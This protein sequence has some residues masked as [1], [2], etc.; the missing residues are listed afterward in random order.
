MAGL[1]GVGAAAFDSV[2]AV[3]ARAAAPTR[4]GTLRYG[5]NTPITSLDPH[6][7]T[8]AAADNCLGI[9]YSRLVQLSPDW[10]AFQPD[11]ADRWTV[12]S[13]GKAYTF[14]LRPNVKFHDG[15]TLTAD[16]VVFSFQRIMDPK[17]GAYVQ[18][19]L[20]DVFDQVVAPD[21]SNVRFVLTRPYSAVLAALALPTASIVSKR[22]V[23][24]GGNLE[25]A[26]MGTGAMKFVSLE[27]GVKITLA[28]HTQYYDPALPYLDGMQLLFLADDTARSTAIRNG[29]VDFIEFV[30]YKDMDAIKSNPQ[31]RYYFDDVAAGLWAFPNVKRPPLDNPMVRQALNW[32]VNREAILKAAFFGHG[33]IMDSVFMPK[34]WWPYSAST[35]KYGYDPDRAKDLLKRSGIKMPARLD[36]LTSTIPYHNAG[37]VVFQANAQDL[38]FQVSLQAPEYAQFVK[39]FL[40][41]DYQIS[42]WGGGPAY[43]DPD[44]LYAYFSDG[45]LIGR[46]T[47]YLNASLA[48]LLDEARLTSDRT[49]R[50]TLYTQAYK[51]IIDDAAFFPFA[52]REQAEAAAP[53]VQGYTRVQGSN[54]YGP[55]IA[56]IWMTK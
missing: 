32:G 34:N 53:N 4:G 7:F 33:A 10:N 46:T 36:M 27:P 52:Y 23:T 39:Q 25:L 55:R 43:P 24:S 13:D 29:S 1:L 40:S 2:S 15:S 18:P 19:L 56:R 5:M 51:I 17:T 49:L 47:G 41:G 38:G 3:P 11:L 9:V 14:H 22:W 8:G 12:S 42:V 21:A 31:L 28:R 20:S 30:P 37:M 45:G 48:T 50:K 35:T 54:W 16:D 44:F 26:Q 6:R